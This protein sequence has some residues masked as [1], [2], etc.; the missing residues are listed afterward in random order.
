MD[1]SISLSMWLDPKAAALQV[2]KSVFDSMSNSMAKQNVY[3]FD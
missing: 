1:I 3:S 2:S